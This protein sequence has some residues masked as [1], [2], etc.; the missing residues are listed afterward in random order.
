VPAEPVGPLRRAFP[1]ERRSAPLYRPWVERLKTRLRRAGLATNDH[2]F[3]LAWSGAMTE[4][5]V[6]RLLPHLPDGVSELYFHP[7]TERTPR[8]VK[9]MPRYRHRDELAALLS[10]ALA[11]RVGECGI[12]LV[13]YG[14]LATA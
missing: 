1:E 13:G 7:A 6:L 5:R 4:E 10:P 9:T 11:K 12:G 14:D 2:L 8:L 3:G